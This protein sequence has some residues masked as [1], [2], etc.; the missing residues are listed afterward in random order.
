MQHSE[1]ATQA[2]LAL[3][4]RLQLPR[5]RPREPGLEASATLAELAWLASRWAGG[6]SL[7]SAVMVA[8]ASRPAQLC[9]RSMMD[10]EQELAA[11]EPLA[12][13]PSQE[14]EA[15]KPLED[16]SPTLES[17]SE[18]AAGTAAASEGAGRPKRLRP[19]PHRFLSGPLARSPWLSPQLILLA[20][21]Q[22]AAVEVA[23]P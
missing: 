2:F 15:V 22:L 12:V 4:A 17:P 11:A 21:E 3:P 18:G 13:E 9:Y 10:S 19:L 6:P 20:R 7:V 16:T 8:T 23:A 5:E 1:K 14:R